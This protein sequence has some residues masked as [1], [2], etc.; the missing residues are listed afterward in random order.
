M[1]S[2]N[3]REKELVLGFI[4]NVKENR[5]LTKEDFDKVYKFFC[6]IVNLEGNEHNIVFE[7]TRLDNRLEHLPQDVAENM[8][9]EEWHGLE[10]ASCDYSDTLGYDMEISIDPVL[11]CKRYLGRE[12]VEERL[13]G[14]IEL[15][16]TIF[17]ESNHAKQ[18]MDVSRKALF[19]RA[20]TFAREMLLRCAEDDFYL[21]NYKVFSLEK[22][23]NI[24]ARNKVLEMAEGTD[25]FEKISSV[26]ASDK[27]REDTFY[28]DLGKVN[29]NGF[30][31]NKERLLERICEQQIANFPSLLYM[32][33]LL[34]KQYDRK[35]QK[36]SLVDVF[37]E[38]FED[39]RTIVKKDEDKSNLS[40]ETE[41][42]CLECQGF[43]YELISPLLDLATEQDYKTLAQRYGVVT[44][45]SVFSS[46]E[47]YFNYTA[48]EKLK[49]V[50]IKN[51]PQY[52]S[53]EEI[54]A[55]LKHKVNAVVRFR[56]GVALNPIA[57]KL[58]R[59]G[60]FIRG[61]REI[62]SLE[63][64]KR[65]QLFVSSLIGTYDA[66]ESERE[67][68]LRV[69]SEK[70]DID[71]IVNSLYFNRGPDLTRKVTAYDENGES[72]FNSE[73]VRLA[74]LLKIAKCMQDTGKRDYIEEF[75]KIPDVNTL[76][77]TLERDKSG[78]LS[79]CIKKAQ[80]RIKKVVYPKTQAEE[81]KYK[82]YILGEGENVEISN[83]IKMLND[84]IDGKSRSIG[85]PR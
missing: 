18:M 64:L 50:G 20:L 47:K 79:H 33:P 71:E 81:G 73:T 14:A 5:F 10:I 52:E 25:F 82:S 3:E 56:N 23:A 43:Y 63:V 30:F 4:K 11:F 32:A 35:G 80:G 85:I 70:E 58:L 44:L 34:Q 68:R 36:L 24:Y 42:K 61:T 13:E 84:E 48:S 26:L 77:S 62:L 7:T 27:N 55:E 67:Y 9:R 53:E 1:N 15:L 12:R 38:M 59:E 57:E 21:K 31:Q 37:D 6:D 78:Y 2:A 29:Y 45:R 8:P 76:I 46:M 65:R 51:G 60:G 72:I 66:I 19:P 28:A 22:Y 69:E 54:K 49:Y 17:H 40:P 39:I 41:K 74:Q 83:K 75:I 16:F